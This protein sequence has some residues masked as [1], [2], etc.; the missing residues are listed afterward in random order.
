MGWWTI[1][2][3]CRQTRKWQFQYPQKPPLT[4]SV[5]VSGKL[6]TQA[7]MVSRL[8]EVLDETR[9]PP[10][11]LRFEITES[12]LLEHADEAMEKLA[13]LRRLGVGLHVDDF[14][15]GYSSLS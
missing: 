11:S 8:R 13:Q 9:L 10:R 5:N 7:N 6:F 4:V 14:G 3:A 2:Q 12:V 1:E 15:T